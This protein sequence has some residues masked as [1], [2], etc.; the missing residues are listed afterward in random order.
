MAVHIVRV[1][2]GDAEVIVNIAL[3]VRTLCGPP[4]PKGRYRFGASLKAQAIRSTLWQ[5]CSTIPSPASQVKLYQFLI[6]HS[7]SLIPSG[8]LEAS[9]IAFTGPA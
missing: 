3:V 8:R 2:V 7:V 9:G 6:C 5:P 1:F 4:L